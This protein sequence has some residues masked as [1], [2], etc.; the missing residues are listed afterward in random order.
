M[1]EKFASAELK[2]HRGV[3][4]GD[5]GSLLSLF[6]VSERFKPMEILTGAEEGSKIKVI[7]EGLGEA[8]L[9]LG[10]DME[11]GQKKTIMTLFAYDERSKPID[12]TKAAEAGANVTVNMWKIQTGNNV[13]ER[14]K[15]ERK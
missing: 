8:D 7:L 11:K 1:M 12:I 15:R 2:L 6:G 4:K 14:K 13:P 9:K 3:N 5:K 10:Q